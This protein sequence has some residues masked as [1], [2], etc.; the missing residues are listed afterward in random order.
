MAEYHPMVIIARHTSKDSQDF[1][2]TISS[3]DTLK[4]IGKYEVT[5]FGGKNLSKELS[6][7]L[8]L[9]PGYMYRFITDNDLAI[10]YIKGEQLTLPTK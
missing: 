3:L 7:E 9:T 1:E 4:F 10:S 8:L 2:N 5:H 6:I